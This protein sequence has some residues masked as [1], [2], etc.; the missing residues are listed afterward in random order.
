MGSN[1][2]QNPDV[3]IEVHLAP[4]V[5][6]LSVSMVMTL[7][8][9]CQIHIKIKSLCNQVLWRP[10]KKQFN[11]HPN[12]FIF[13]SWKNHIDSTSKS[14][15]KY[16]KSLGTQCL[17]QW[18]ES[19]KHAK[20]SLNHSRRPRFGSHENPKGMQKSHAKSH[21]FAQF[22][23]GAST[24][25]YLH[26]DLNILRS[27][28]LGHVSG[29]MVLPTSDC[30]SV[31][32]S[33]CGGLYGRATALWKRYERYTHDTIFIHAEHHGH[34]LSK[35]ERLTGY[36]QCFLSWEHD[37]RDAWRLINR[38]DERTIKDNYRVPFPTSISTSAVT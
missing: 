35:T 16:I 21:L 6:R 24:G 33:R 14:S 31:Q 3:I 20:I 34:C 19:S 28:P 1:I 30:T 36:Q 2:L 12:K 13:S 22:K 38:S 27:D 15:V 4:Q 10:V 18:T 9:K 32:G 17:T 37:F 25:L 23:S 5:S 8:K 29:S 11:N 7:A 26:H